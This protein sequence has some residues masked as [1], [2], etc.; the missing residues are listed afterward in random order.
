MISL[1]YLPQSNKLTCVVV[2]AKDLPPKDITG[3]SGNP[4]N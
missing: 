3:S 4:R 1:C 2:K